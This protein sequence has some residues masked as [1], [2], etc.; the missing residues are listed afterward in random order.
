MLR[1]SCATQE[2]PLFSK[3]HAECQGEVIFI[4]ACLKLTILSGEKYGRD[5]YFSF[6]GIRN[7]VLFD[8]ASV[9]NTTH[10]ISLLQR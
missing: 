6:K 10:A 5:I 1:M 9:A 8:I 3:P 7:K 4:R 2:A